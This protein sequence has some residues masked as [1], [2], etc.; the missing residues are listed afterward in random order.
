MNRKGY[1]VTVWELFTFCVGIYYVKLLGRVC[2]RV[3]DILSQCC[4]KIGFR[5]YV[6]IR[7]VN[8]TPRLD[9]ISYDTALSNSNKNFCLCSILAESDLLGKLA[10]F[11]NVVLTVNYL[12]SNVNVN[13]KHTHVEL[14]GCRI[15]EQRILDRHVCS[16]EIVAKSLNEYVKSKVL[17]RGKSLQYYRIVIDVIDH[18]C[19]SECE[20]FESARLY[21]NI[22]ILISVTRKVGDRICVCAEKSVVRAALQVEHVQ[23]CQSTEERTLITGQS[24][25]ILIGIGNFLSDLLGIKRK[26]LNL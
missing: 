19:R 22:S 5:S 3:V 16:L 21:L 9:R 1:L 6:L 2:D 17:L 26:I 12:K 25:Q 10:V 8:I 4:R 14:N 7:N 23:N 15:S 24:I 20:L 18:P 13:V 11:N